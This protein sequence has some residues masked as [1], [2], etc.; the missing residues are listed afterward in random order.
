MILEVKE[1]YDERLKMIWFLTTTTVCFVK[2]A[3]NYFLMDDCSY[4]CH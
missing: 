1:K 2:A 4:C 3:D